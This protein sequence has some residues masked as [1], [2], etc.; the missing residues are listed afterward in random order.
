MEEEQ[1]TIAEI[2]DIVERN[3]YTEFTT[4]ERLIY[5]G[6]VEKINHLAFIIIDT[7]GFEILASFRTTSSGIYEVQLNVGGTWYLQ[8]FINFREKI[9]DELRK[10]KY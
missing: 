3:F 10:A 7:R 1:L 8:H 4:D 5:L 2:K 6:A 9:I